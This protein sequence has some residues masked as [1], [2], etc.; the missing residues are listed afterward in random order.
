LFGVNA[1]VVTAGRVRAGDPVAVTEPLLPAAP[2]PATDW[3][4]A[5]RGALGGSSLAPQWD[6]GVS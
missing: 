6:M 4:V 1:R 2:R 3:D 5:P